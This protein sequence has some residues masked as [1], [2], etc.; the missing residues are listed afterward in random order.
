MGILP[1]RYSW[2]L[3][4]SHRSDARKRAGPTDHPIITDAYEPYRRVDH[5]HA[6]RMANAHPGRAQLVTTNGLGH[7]RILADPSVIA[8]VVAFL[9]APEAMRD[10]A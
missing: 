2:A 8:G 7:H 6:V 1:R 9:S 10:A 3:R 5:A 4:S